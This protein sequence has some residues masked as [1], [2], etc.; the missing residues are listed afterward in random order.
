MLPLIRGLVQPG[1]GNHDPEAKYIGISLRLGSI[2]ANFLILIQKKNF[3]EKLQFLMKQSKSEN[4]GKSRESPKNSREIS[5]ILEQLGIL[6]NYTHFPRN[7]PRMFSHSRILGFPVSRF[8]GVLFYVI[9]CCSRF[10]GFSDSRF[11][12]FSVSRILVFSD[13][14]FLGFSFSRILGFSVICLEVSEG[15]IPGAAF[16]KP[17]IEIQ[18]DSILEKLI[19]IYLYI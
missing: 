2:G 13:S 11:L 3:V 17:I 18:S 1:N 6:E 19:P 5:W 12:G 7:C 9:L 10:L 16:F 4:P 14:R 8:L 15:F